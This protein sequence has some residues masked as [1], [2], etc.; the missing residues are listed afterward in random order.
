MESQIE[1]IEQKAEYADDGAAWIGQVEFSKSGKMI[2][3]N[4]HALNFSY[5]CCI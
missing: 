3:L 1:Y 4:G 2:Y 5:I